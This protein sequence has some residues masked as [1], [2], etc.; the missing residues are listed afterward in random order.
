MNKAARSAT[1][2][3]QPGQLEEQITVLMD[4]YELFAKT[5]YSRKEARTGPYGWAD[6]FSEQAHVNLEDGVGYLRRLEEAETVKVRLKKPGLPLQPALDALPAPEKVKHLDLAH[7]ALNGALNLSCFT[8]LRVVAL[9][10]NP[11]LALGDCAL[12]ASLEHILLSREEAAKLAKMDFHNAFPGI[13]V[14]QNGNPAFSLGIAPFKEPEMA[15]VKGGG[16]WMGS[17]EEAPNEDEKPQHRVHLPDFRIGKYPV[18]VEEY[19]RFIYETS[20]VTEVEKEGW[21]VAAFWRGDSLDYY[22]KIGCNWRHDAYGRPM[23]NSFARHPVIHISWQDAVAYCRWLSWKTGR[24]YNLPTEAQWEYAAIGGHKAGKKD[25]EGSA[26]APFLYAG[27]DALEDVGWFLGKF[28]GR[29][30][31]DYSTKPV[32]RLQ[33]NELGLYDMSGHVWEWCADW[34]DEQCYSKRA[35]EGLKKG[36]AGPEHGDSRVLRGGGWYRSARNCRVA[37]R[38][39]YD[40]R[41]RNFNTGFRLHAA[42]DYK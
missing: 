27:S 22:C 35:K 41:Y 3:F 25:E 40:P 24:S 28:E 38:S 36:P 13:A 42:P 23:D 37:N 4:S 34:Y 10:G 14:S 12:P 31:Q 17:G 39:S 29:P 19:A 2:R 6:Y 7:N 5:Y 30:M 33:P 8:Q 11:A 1:A 20:Y 16:F 18:T 32:G 21:S 15:E 9:A 26:F